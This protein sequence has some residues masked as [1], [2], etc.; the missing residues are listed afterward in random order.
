M[1]GGQWGPAVGDRFLVVKVR[2]REG[3]QAVA[4]TDPIRL[5]RVL[6]DLLDHRER[7]EDGR[8][9]GPDAAYF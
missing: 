4:T 8:S 6:V 3:Y 9:G 1:A 7:P 2:G 5:A